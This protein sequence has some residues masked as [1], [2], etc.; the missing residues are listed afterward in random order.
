MVEV[1]LPNAHISAKPKFQQEEQG[2]PSQLLK[3]LWRYVGWDQEKEYE[4]K[5]IVFMEIPHPTHSVQGTLQL[6][7]LLPMTCNLLE[8][9]S[10]WLYLPDELLNHGRAECYKVTLPWEADLFP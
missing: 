7:C 6:P 8:A 9:G 5:V 10:L 1:S 2:C 3:I 4:Q